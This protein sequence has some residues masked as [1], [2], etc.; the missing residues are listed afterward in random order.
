VA[1]VALKARLKAGPTDIEALLLDAAGK[2]LCGAFYLYVGE[3]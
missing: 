1:F 3:S 2:E